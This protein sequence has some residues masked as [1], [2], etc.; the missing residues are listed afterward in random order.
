MKYCRKDP[1]SCRDPVCV[2]ACGFSPFRRTIC[3]AGFACNATQC[4][5]RR[6]GASLIV[7]PSDL[8]LIQLQLNQESGLAS[9]IAYD[10]FCLI[11][12]VFCFVL[13]YEYH[14]VY[15][16]YE[17]WEI[18]N[19]WYMYMTTLDI[20]FIIVRVVYHKQQTPTLFKYINDVLVNPNTFQYLYYI[21]RPTLI[22]H[23]N[24][25]S[26]INRD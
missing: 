5:F 19:W 4:C 9:H 24:L 6:Y 7:W 17:R 14:Y 1:S 15:I 26:K 12:Y 2:R 20:L 10:T 16:F 18:I 3:V 13:L 25:E 21:W 11:I 22:F 23:I 8:G